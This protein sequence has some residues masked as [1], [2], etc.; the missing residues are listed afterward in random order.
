MF[1]H[2]TEQIVMINKL[3]TEFLDRWN[4]NEK[5]IRVKT[6]SIYF[7]LIFIFNND[8]LEICLIDI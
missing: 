2:S 3:I 8:M 7:T 1:S 6:S 4:I 5:E